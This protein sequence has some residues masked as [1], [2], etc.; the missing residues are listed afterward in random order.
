MVLGRQPELF[1]IVVVVTKFRGGW[2]ARAVDAV[3]T[4]AR[5]RIRFRGCISV[6]VLKRGGERQWKGCSSFGIR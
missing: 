1:V 5:G 2:G 4:K 3:V 6:I